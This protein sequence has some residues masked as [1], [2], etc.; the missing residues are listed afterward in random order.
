MM[1][2]QLV[3]HQPQA[4]GRILQGTPAWVWGLLAALMALGL[5]QTLAR[6]ASTARV[7][8]L[9]AAMSVLSLVGVV[10][11]FSSSGR[12]GAT[13]VAWLASAAAVMFVLRHLKPARHARFDPQARR[14]HLPGSWLPLVLIAA[15]FSLKYMVGIELALQPQ[16]AQ[17]PTFALTVC[18]VYGAL[19][20]IFAARALALWRMTTASH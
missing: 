13:L 15:I 19:T 5:S 20:G 18:A 10:S 2:F 9:P 3:T 1:L 7:L 12:L 8:A 14:F 16:T 11:A 6:Q 17:Q 4:V